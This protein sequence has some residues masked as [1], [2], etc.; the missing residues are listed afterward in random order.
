MSVLLPA[1]A[2]NARTGLTGSVAHRPGPD[3]HRVTAGTVDRL[4]VMHA[5]CEPNQGGAALPVFVARAA[6]VQLFL[7]AGKSGS[8][9]KT[10]Q[11][12]RTCSTMGPGNVETAWPMAGL[13]TLFA[14]WR[15]RIS[16]IA[17]RASGES[18]HALAEMAR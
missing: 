10:N 12:G 9:S 18:L 4:H 14:V 6:R 3:M 7:P 1:V 17:V 13:A 2:I 8:P 11:S 16:V 15:R 5:A